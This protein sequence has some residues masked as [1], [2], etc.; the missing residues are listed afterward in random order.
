[1]ATEAAD[2]SQ[3]ARRQPA[4]EA[5]IEQRASATV[6]VPERLLLGSG[7][8]PVPERVYAGLGQPTI[9]HLDPVFGQVMDE[10]SALLRTVFGTGNRATVAL[11]T[12]GSGGMD[13]LVA[14]CVSPGD[15]VVCGVNGLFGTRM[16]DALRRMGADVVRVQAPWGRAIPIEDLMA[17]G[18]AGLDSMV[19]VHGETSTGVCQPLEGLAEFCRERDAL[20]MIDCVTSLAGSQ[21]LIDEWGVDAAFSGSQ[22]CLN[23]PPG[24]APFTVGQRALDK[25]ARRPTPVPTWSYDISLLLDYWAAEEGR[26]YHH[27]APTNMVLALHEALRIAVE[28]GLPERWAR[29]R[30][31]HQALRSALAVLGCERLTYDGEE[32]NPLIPVRPPSE[33]DEAEVRGALLNKHGIEISGGLGELAGTWRIGVMGM[34]ARPGPQRR[35]VQAL[36]EELGRN[37]AEALSALDTSWKQQHASTG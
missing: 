32:L 3:A 16:A 14:N 18:K 12:T 20:L 6:Q 7:P 11:P 1:M 36:A 29:H 9:G 31:A 34:G 24:L 25:I 19:L 28:E 13:A 26:R 37:P 27:T 23:C 4:G 35:L 2:S 8:S 10:T 5:S 17:A 22:K 30:T 21:V 15:R 33:V